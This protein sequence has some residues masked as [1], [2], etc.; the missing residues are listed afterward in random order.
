[1]I[2]SAADESVSQIQLW[3]VPY[4]SGQAQRITKDSNDY[5]SISLTAN[6]KGLVAIQQNRRKAI[7]VAPNGDANQARQVA[8]A[9]GQT[10]GLAWTP[11]A[12]IIYSTMASGKLDLWSVGSDGTGK[13][14][15]TLNA[16]SNYHPSVSPNGRYIVF[17]SDRTGTFNIW[18]MDADGGNPKQLTNSGSDFRP[19]C[20]PDGKWIVYQRG[21]GASGK[22]TLWKVSVD[23]GDPVQLT[24]INSSV[25]AISPD[26]KLI[27]CRFVDATDDSKKI[28]IIPFGGGVPVKTFGITIKPWQRVRWTSDAAALTYIDV[29][30]GISNI[31]RQPLDGGPPSQLTFFK[32]DQIFSYDW[33]RDGKQLACERGLETTDVIS[34]SSNR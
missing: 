16:G 11:D 24:D 4:P 5:I 14:Q 33:S 30:G 6:S 9:V 23:G 12:R 1:M 10:Y 8:S 21:D 7:W 27:A 31:W 2:I 3:Y 26:G 34:I 28:A 13:T 22:P 18:R 29:R 20:S 15:L 25:P 17:A 19:D 32:A